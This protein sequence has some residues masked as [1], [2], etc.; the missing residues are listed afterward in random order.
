MLDSIIDFLHHNVEYVYPVLFLG[1]FIESFFPPYPSDG[2]FVFS[3]F[4]A[5]R[6][7]LDGS[8]AFL[9]VS[10]GNFI[11]VMSIYLLGLK[12]IRPYLSRWISNEETISRVDRWFGRY[13]DKVILF[14]RFIPGIRAPLCFS[15]GLFRLSPRKMAFY[16]TLSI[17]G[18]NGLL[19]GMSSWAGRNFANIERFLLRY[20]VIAGSVTCVV[21]VWSLI[22]FWRRRKHS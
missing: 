17:I 21:V 11:G 2:V 20:G 4:L 9:L 12:G 8:K 1:S 7:V 15:A 3:A 6:G 5:G 16:S 18:W 14:N 13:G 22:W 19:L 10:T